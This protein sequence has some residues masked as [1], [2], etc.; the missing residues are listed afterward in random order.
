M[1]LTTPPTAGLPPFYS[2]RKAK[3]PEAQQVASLL[4]NAR[5][6]LIAGAS[7]CLWL[8]HTDEMKTLLLDFV[9]D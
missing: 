9:R 2:E 3:E 6:S 8:I 5:F 4:P 7:H 1:L